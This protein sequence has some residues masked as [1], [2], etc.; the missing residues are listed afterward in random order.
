MAGA[1]MIRMAMADHGAVNGAER[2]NEEPTRFA[3]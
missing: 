2:V 1:R 3:E